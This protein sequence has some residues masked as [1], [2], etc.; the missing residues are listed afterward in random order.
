MS[1]NL[2]DYDNGTEGALAFARDCLGINL[3]SKQQEAVASIVE[4]ERTV[5]VGGHSTGITYACAV[6]AEWWFSCRAENVVLDRYW[7]SALR[8]QMELFRSRLWLGGYAAKPG[9]RHVWG[10]SNLLAP[11]NLCLVSSYPGIFGGQVCPKG[12]H[13]DEGRHL[14]VH[15]RPWVETKAL[16]ESSDWNLVQMRAD[17]CI[18]ETKEQIPGLVNQ[19]FVDGIETWKGS[20]HG[21]G[22]LGEFE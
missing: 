13:V 7:N 15:G 2:A 11:G 10:I 9:L 21:I 5:V 3:W 16:A 18:A 4:N 12:V 20:P 19:A 8:K 1:K 6:A 22:V 14:V 17:D